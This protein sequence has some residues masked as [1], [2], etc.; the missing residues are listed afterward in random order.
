[1]RRRGNAREEPVLMNERVWMCVKEIMKVNSR[2]IHARLCI[3]MEFWSVI[4]VH[5]PG[6][7]ESE[8]ERDKS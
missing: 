2:I 4:N 3:K 5:A 6:M 7:E 8:E 1:M